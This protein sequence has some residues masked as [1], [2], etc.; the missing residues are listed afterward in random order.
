MVCFEVFVNGQLICTAGVTEG[1]VVASLSY[2]RTEADDQ[3]RLNVGGISF[4]FGDDLAPRLREALRNTDQPQHPMTWH[5]GR[6][7]VH[8]E[9]TIK[10]VERPTCDSPKA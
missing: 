1:V 7:G 4:G 5:T 3:G 8:D 10:I 2:S 6:V 9:I